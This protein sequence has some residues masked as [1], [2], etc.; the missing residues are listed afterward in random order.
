MKI[1]ILNSA[2]NDLLEGKLFYE[3]QSENLGDYFVNSLL[4]DIDSLVLHGSIHMEVFGFHRLLS[5]RFPYAIYYKMD[6][7]NELTVWRVLD[8]RQNPEKTKLQLDQ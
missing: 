5:K 6:S 7:E 2:Y 1:R 3:K 4:A 8:C